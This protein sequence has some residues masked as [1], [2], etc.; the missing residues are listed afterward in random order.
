MVNNSYSIGFNLCS[1]GLTAVG[2][3]Q[4]ITHQTQLNVGM[5]QENRVCQILEV[6][7]RNKSKIY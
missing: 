3:G 1:V 4:L 2:W 7:T 6:S 5:S